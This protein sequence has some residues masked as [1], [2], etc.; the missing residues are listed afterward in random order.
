MSKPVVID[1]QPIVITMS[2]GIAESELRLSHSS[3]TALFKA[4]D[5]AI[6][7]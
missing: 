1:G 6:M 7:R 3:F 2:V 5:Q 4:V